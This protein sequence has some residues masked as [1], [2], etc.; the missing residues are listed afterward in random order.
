[1]HSPLLEV[2][3]LTIGYLGIC[4]ERDDRARVIRGVPYEVTT[5]EVVGGLRESHDGRELLIKVVWN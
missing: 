1:M 2:R 3:K 4:I 5:D